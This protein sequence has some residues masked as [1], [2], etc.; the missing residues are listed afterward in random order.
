MEIIS[1]TICYFGKLIL[2]NK[3]KL[4]QYLPYYQG[5]KELFKIISLL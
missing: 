1:Y 4:K 5:I 3:F 2:G